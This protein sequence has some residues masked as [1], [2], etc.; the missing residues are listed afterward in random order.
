MRE[1]LARVINVFRRGGLERQTET[2]LRFHLEMET[3]ARM[4]RGLSRAEAERQARLRAGFISTASEA[5]RDQRGLGWFDGLG[6][7]LHEAWV[8]LRRRPSFLLTAGATLAAAVAVNT[9]VF[10]IV[11]GVLL[12]PILPYPEPDRLV[13]IFEQSAPEPKFPVSIYNY[14]E[15]LKSEPH[16]VRHRALHP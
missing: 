5:V 3:E 4:R 8:A 13:R 14:L 10:A 12:R 16:A 7:D 15:D 2:E 9:L 1:L 6:T 11:Y